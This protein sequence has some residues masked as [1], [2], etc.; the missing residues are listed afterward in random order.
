[1]FVKG[2]AVDKNVNLKFL[3]IKCIAKVNEKCHVSPN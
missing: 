1:M 2:S 3:Y